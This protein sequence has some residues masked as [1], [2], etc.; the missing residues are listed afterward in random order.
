MFGVF[1]WV[2]GFAWVV[3]FWV[4]CD[5]VILVWMDCVFCCCL[6]LTDVCGLG[7]GGFG[8]GDLVNW[9]FCCFGLGFG[10]LFC[11]IFVI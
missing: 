11:L 8:C 9:R 1:F 5:F 2:G 7:W 3:W 4:G 10:F 6:G